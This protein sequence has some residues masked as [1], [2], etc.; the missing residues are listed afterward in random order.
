MTLKDLIDSPELWNQLK[1]EAKKCA[2]NGVLHRD[3]IMPKIC[4]DCYYRMLGEEIEKHPI[5][6]RS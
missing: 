1:Q 3:R 2:C 5:G 4:D 6:R